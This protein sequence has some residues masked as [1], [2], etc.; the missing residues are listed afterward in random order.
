MQQVFEIIPETASYTA[1]SRTTIK[2]WLQKVGYYKLKR[3]KTKADDWIVIIDASIQ[4]GDQKCLLF[5]GIQESKLPKNRALKVDDMVLL[6]LRV[7]SSLNSKLITEE[8]KKT[9]S[10]IGTIKCICSDQGS[11]MVRG[12]KDFQ[13]ISPKTKHVCDTAHYVANALK[14]ILEKNEAWKKFRESTTQS[15]RK[16]QNSKISG[17]LPPSPRTKAR[18]MNVDSLIEWASDMLILLDKGVSSPEINIEELK[19]YLEWLPNYRT[20]IHYWNRLVSVG[21]TA[22]QLVREQGMHYDIDYHFEQAVSGI[23]LGARELPYVDKI[24]SF[25]SIQSREMQIGERYVGSTEIIETFFGKLKYTEGEQT[26]FGFTSLVLAAMACIGPTNFEIVKESI[27]SVTEKEINSWTKE[28]IGESVQ[29]QRMKIKKYVRDLRAVGLDSSS[30]AT[31]KINSSIEKIEK[32]ELL[33]RLKL[34]P[35][36]AE[37]MERDFSGILEEKIMGF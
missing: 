33:E 4:M 36:F 14:A 10:S 20:E 18:F 13:M 6:G 35:Y 37:K 27:T 23:S 9:A 31:S 26:A 16:M 19:R 8:L 29:S 25:L 28:E 17:A 2:R 3:Q 11:D 21:A 32:A 5:I 1:P 34:K 22:R 7:V 24:T 12:I 15:R 30:Q